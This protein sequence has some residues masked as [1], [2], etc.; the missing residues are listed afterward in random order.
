MNR[1]T[2]KMVILAL[3]NYSDQ[4]C[5]I[6]CYSWSKRHDAKIIMLVEINESGS[7]YH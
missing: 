3:L 7:E 5:I 2:I 4:L 6:I 1:I